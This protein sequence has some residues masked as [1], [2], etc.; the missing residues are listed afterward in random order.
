MS[1]EIRKKYKGLN[2]MEYINKRINGIVYYGADNGTVTL[3]EFK[4]IQQA[5]TPPTAEEVCK[6]LSEWSGD[7]WYYK[8]NMQRKGFVCN[9][10]SFTNEKYIGYDNKLGLGYF[11]NGL[12]LPPHLITLI[13]KFYEG[14][15]K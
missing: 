7:K 1:R 2:A 3:D 15:N 6:A 8:T 11:Q 10:Q 12:W 4:L 9:E 14:E 13:G 5:L